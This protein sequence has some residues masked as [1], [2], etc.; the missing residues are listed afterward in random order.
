MDDELIWWKREEKKIQ[1]RNQ[2]GFERKLSLWVGLRW[3]TLMAMV[4]ISSTWMIWWKTE[5]KKMH[6]RKQTNESRISP[7]WS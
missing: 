3:M 4:A 1:N 2:L 6:N 7:E 5:E